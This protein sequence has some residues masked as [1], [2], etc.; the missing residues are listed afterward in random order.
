MGGGEE[1]EE[2]ERRE[3]RSDEEGSRDERGEKVVW[4]YIR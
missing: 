1:E 3:I 4:L 2:E